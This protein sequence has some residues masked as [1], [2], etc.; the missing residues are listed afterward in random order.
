MA[1]SCPCPNTST[2]RPLATA[3]F[4]EPFP[5]INVGDCWGNGIRSWDRGASQRGRHVV[6]QHNVES[7]FSMMKRKF[8]DSVRSKTA[9]AIWNEVLAKVLCHKV[10]VVIH[11]THELGSSSSSR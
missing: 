10:V 8:G 5:P 11:E 3:A 1:R 6:W 7:T 2:S 9:V 4:C